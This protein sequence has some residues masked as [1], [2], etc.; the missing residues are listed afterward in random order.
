MHGRHIATFALAAVFLLVLAACAGTGGTTSDPLNGTSWQ[1]T[2][3]SGA[4]LVPGT[5]ITATFEDGEVSGKAC[6]NYGGEYQVSGDKLTITRV[7]WTEMACLD[8]QGIM[9]QETAYLKLL[10]TAQSFKLT[11]GRLLIVGAGG[12]E[13]AFAPAQ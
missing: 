1:V 13:L 5:E 10:T 9:E 8:P 12:E 7:F 3:L 6:N 2:T 11:A 4:S